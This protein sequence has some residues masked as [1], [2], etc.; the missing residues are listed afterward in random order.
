[1]NFQVIKD[2]IVEKFE[3]ARDQV[4]AEREQ[5]LDLKGLV[6]GLAA[7]KN[8]VE[9]E[10]VA[11]AVLQESTEE[12]FTLITENNDE[13]DFLSEDHIKNIGSYWAELGRNL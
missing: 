6:S 13:K 10:N 11:G 2:L 1:M 3:S 9:S 4:I 8:L 5:K 7:A 12:Y